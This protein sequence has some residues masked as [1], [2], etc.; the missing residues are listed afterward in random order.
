[1]LVYLDHLSDQLINQ[2]L[3]VAPV[4]TAS[5]METVSLSD[6]SASRGSQLEGPQESVDLLEVGT[7]GVDLVDDVLS[8]VDTEMAEVLGDE[9]VVGQGD[10]GTL[11]LKVASLVDKLSDGGQRRVS[12]G[13]IGSDDSE[14]LLNGSVDLEED[15]VVELLQ[16]EELQDLSG[17]GSHLVD[18]DESGSEQELGLGLN[19][20]VAVLSGLTSESDQVS[21]TSSVLLQV[22]DR[23]R[24]EFLSGLRSGLRV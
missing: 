5:L 17:L 6:E 18:T 23:A 24:L 8:T 9:G 7:N 10:S 15:T 16:S 11:D 1:M 13:D 14:H 2:M 21:L 19:E 12:E 22:L 4:T 20:E 3:S